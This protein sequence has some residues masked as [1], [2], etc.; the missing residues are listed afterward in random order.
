MLL[1]SVTFGTK[2]VVNKETS[3]KRIRSSAML[4]CCMEPCQLV[5][6]FTADSPPKVIKNNMKK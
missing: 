4:L 1:L 6:L 2:K 3:W 5:S